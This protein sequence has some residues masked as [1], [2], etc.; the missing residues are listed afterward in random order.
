MTSAVAALRQME[1]TIRSDIWRRWMS[2][3]QRRAL[4]W[5]RDRRVSPGLAARFTVS[6]AAY[7]GFGERR[8]NPY[9][10]KPYYHVGGSLEQLQRTYR[11][12]TI[13]G[14][15]LVE[16]R[17]TFGGGNLRFLDTPKQRPVVGWA[18]RQVSTVTQQRSGTTTT[19]TS[20]RRVPVRGGDTYAAAFG[21]FGKDR[22]VIEARV[23]IELRKIVRAAAYTKAGK[24]RSSVLRQDEEQSA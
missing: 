15:G 6:G 11:P 1:N 4:L 16:S 12:R 20:T 3:A 14:A 17:L 13:R 9:R 24:L 23:A 8:F 2:A 7:Y 19:I 18:T 22:A 5:W 21:A 10:V